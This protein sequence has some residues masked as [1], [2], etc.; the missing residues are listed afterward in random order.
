MHQRMNNLLILPKFCSRA[1]CVTARSGGNRTRHR[2]DGGFESFVLTVYWYRTYVHTSPVQ[3]TDDEQRAAV[4]QG[5]VRVSFHKSSS[6]WSTCKLHLTYLRVLGKR[7]NLNTKQ[8]G[9][10]ERQLSTTF[11]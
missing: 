11:F 8:L 3:Q 9:A 2:R 6:L 7:N 10:L 1:L 5:A 4:R